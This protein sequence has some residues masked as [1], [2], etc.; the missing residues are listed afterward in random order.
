MF[1]NCPIVLC[2]IAFRFCNW[3][4]FSLFT[5]ICELHPNSFVCL[6]FCCFFI[7][8]KIYSSIR[9]TFTHTMHVFFFIVAAYRLRVLVTMCRSGKSC[10]WQKVKFVYIAML[11]LLQWQRTKQKSVMNVVCMFGGSD[12]VITVWNTRK[13]F[14]NLNVFCQIGPVDT[15]T[16]LHISH[17]RMHIRCTRLD[18]HLN[19]LDMLNK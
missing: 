3:C 6:Y 8:K 12:D 15:H 10:E 11:Y 9:R 7:L 2:A 5:Y 17:T 4:F 13:S 19:R 18:F 1:S 14:Y 16:Y